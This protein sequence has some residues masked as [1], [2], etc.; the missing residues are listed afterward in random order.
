MKIRYE[1]VSDVG[2]ARTNNEDMALVFGAFIRD[3]EAASTVRMDSRPRFTAIVADGMGGY[4]GGEIASE[5]TL[6][7]FDQFFSNMPD[8]L[9]DTDVRVA[10]NN[11][12]E[13]H[14]RLI[15]A[16]QT[17]PGLEQMGTT[18]T[19]MFTYGD[20]T[21]MLNAGDS[22]VYRFRNG[23]LRQ[24]SVDHSE[25]ERL[26]D[27]TV[28]SNLIYNAIGVPGAFITLTLLDEKFPVV[29]G[30]RYIICSDGLSDM[31]DDDTIAS[32]L[33]EGGGAAQLVS[34]ALE[35]GGHDNC[36]VIVLTVSKPDDE[37]LHEQAETATAPVQEPEIVVAP[38]PIF[39]DANIP[40]EDTAPRQAMPAEAESEPVPPPFDPAEMGGVKP[41][42]A[43]RDREE[44][45][46]GPTSE[47]V[48]EVTDERPVSFRERLRA[49][50]GLLNEAIN[51][52]R[53]GKKHN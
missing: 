22:R 13:A 45:T 7:S 41:L 10:V 35:A 2:R 40:A 39:I 25:R 17:K 30:D 43:H 47:V 46:A 51:T 24:L 28:P 32:I 33:E 34:A 31:I 15:E 27:P 42:F 19:G 20:R 9:N 21:Y 8:D 6:K 52:L 38:E 50:G 4:G 1:V 11:W 53:G 14:Q 16:E 12:L 36:T 49:A 3:G 29:D 44:K 37:Q 48:S 26:G 18:V 23:G 5:M